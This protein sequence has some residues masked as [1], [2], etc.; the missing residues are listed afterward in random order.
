MKTSETWNPGF[1]DMRFDIQNGHVFT[2][3][4]GLSPGLQ[5]P[6]IFESQE[7]PIELTHLPSKNQNQPEYFIYPPN[8]DSN[9]GRGQ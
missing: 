2:S 8:P 4:D 1:E 7:L 6:F 5:L 3:E 9:S